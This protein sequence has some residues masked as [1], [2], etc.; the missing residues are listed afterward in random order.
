METMKP[1]GYE[2]LICDNL[3]AVTGIENKA[4]TC[5]WN[6]NLI[7]TLPDLTA[8]NGPHYPSANDKA[9]K[10]GKHNSAVY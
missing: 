6:Q 3:V 10:L 1:G 4:R 5:I 2:V 9:K 8:G 7:F